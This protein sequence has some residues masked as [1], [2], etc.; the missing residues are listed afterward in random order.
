MSIALLSKSY[1]LGPSSRSRAGN[2]DSDFHCTTQYK[3]SS[4]C[5]ALNC[6]LFGTHYAHGSVPLS[7]IIPVWWVRVLRKWKIQFQFNVLVLRGTDRCI[8]WCFHG[9][10]GRCI[11]WYFQAQTDAY[12]TKNPGNEVFQTFAR[13]TNR[14]TSLCIYYSTDGIVQCRRWNNFSNSEDNNQELVINP[15]FCGEASTSFTKRWMSEQHGLWSSRGEPDT[16]GCVR[17]WKMAW[18]CIRESRERNSLEDGRCPR[19][20]FKCLRRV[21]RMGDVP[22]MGE[23][24][25]N[26]REWEMSQGWESLD[27]LKWKMPEDCSSWGTMRVL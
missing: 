1:F 25:L 27:S 7:E 21:A 20:G 8:C 10:T 19:M 2:L 18:G 5:I 11:W 22:S 23:E 13:V 15:G 26:S 14:F 3:L 9:G 4:I 16:L 6:L 17:G 24:S 12:V